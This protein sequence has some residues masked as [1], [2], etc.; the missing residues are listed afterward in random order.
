MKFVPRTDDTPT[1]VD[2]SV[3]ETLTLAREFSASG[4]RSTWRLGRFTLRQ[5]LGKGG[6]GEVYRAYDSVLDR[7]VALKVPRIGHDD[8]GLL[9][10][11][12]AEA[13]LAGRLRHPNIVAVYESDVVD[14]HVFIAT[15]FVHGETLA[16]RIKRD[17]P[18]PATAARWVAELADALHYA[19]SHGVV[20]RD[21]KPHN[22]M[23]DTSERPQL[24]D[25][26]LAKRLDEASSLTTEGSLLGTPAYMSP[27]QARGE[28]SRVGPASDQYSLGVVLYELLTGQRP[29]DGP[30][31]KVI[32][33]AAMEE[34]PAPS[35]VAPGIPVDLEAVCLKAMNKEIPRRYASAG[36]F[37]EDLRRW[38]R[39]DE[40]QARPIGQWERLDRW[41]R[42]NRTISRLVAAVAISLLAGMLVSVFFAAIASE[43]ATRA[44]SAQS[45]ADAK[46]IL[47]RNN[48]D[49]ANAS[50]ELAA[51]RADRLQWQLYISNVNRA[52]IELNQNNYGNAIRL[53]AE[54]PEGLRGW[55]WR[56]VNG[57]C[58]LELV[59]IPG[60][61]LPRTVRYTYGR[62]HCIAFSPDG[63]SIVWQGADLRLRLWDP[64]T[65]RPKQVFADY[66]GSVLSVAFSKNGQLLAA[67]CD[68][69]YVRIWE[70][71]TGNIL[72]KLPIVDSP[73]DVD[74]QG[75]DCVTFIRN[76][77][78]VFAATQKDYGVWEI[79]SGKRSIQL[80]LKSPEF[81][82][83]TTVAPSEKQFVVATDKSNVFFFDMETGRQRRRVPIQNELAL[84]TSF[85]PDQTMAATAAKDRIVLWD[86]KSGE[87]VKSLEGAIAKRVA[88]SEDGKRLVAGGEDRTMQI[89]DLA[90]GRRLVTYRGH[91]D[92][93]NSVALSPDGSL[94]ASAG[95]DGTLKIWDAT[96]DRSGIVFKHPNAVVRGFW[97]PDGRGIATVYQTQVL[98]W[99]FGNTQPSREIPLTRS[100]W[101]PV[102]WH[103]DYREF[104]YAGR[105]GQLVLCDTHSYRETQRLFEPGEMVRAI[106]YAPNGDRLVTT[107][108]DKLVILDTKSHRSI[109]EYPLDFEHY[110][111]AASDQATRHVALGG[112]GQI[113]L[114]DA[115][116]GRTIVHVHL[117]GGRTTSLPPVCFSPNGEHFLH[118]D[119]AD[120]VMRSVATGEE[121]RRL[122]GH[123]VVVNDVK[124]TPDGTRIASVSDDTTIKFWDPTS[125]DVVFSFR[126][127]NSGFVWLEFSR[128]GNHLLTG[129]FDRTA[130]VWDATVVSPQNRSGTPLE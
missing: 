87:I 12:V 103:P 43:R 37:A 82:F 39:H 49:A 76:D 90:T 130:R 116:T 41:R 121:V 7:E 73:Q 97:L 118:G 51:Q 71:A 98:L 9:K 106:V 16:A 80:P 23:L 38:M 94:A 70:V 18:D 2:G 17:R 123:T 113:L 36:E 52:F 67:G 108:R 68:D 46:A 25:F 122:T 83:S 31:H 24:M 110:G 5:L 45:E 10:R 60:P 111:R 62:E 85:S 96:R 63:S 124:Y 61:Q 56:Y 117:P 14:G 100:Y 127:E 66:D 95:Q 30:S 28:N 84:N 8:S 53:L 125:G 78:A 102:A 50:A 77:T 64:R 1:S 26:G 126:N 4:E 29:F 74:A 91:T 32:A 59:A 69:F 104:A 101:Y 72:H 3:S 115:A 57:L 13:K 44:I 105:N 48:A 99:E 86:V 79:P 20:H 40:T 27:E 89:W 75:I 21:V 34:P 54:C 11:F 6:F 119:G 81:N 55:E 93:V 129:G 35:R 112:D 120:I 22:I 33:A 114:L 15:E 47:A 58:H 128:D 19:H 92:I 42:R 109:A 88:F 107:L 65:G